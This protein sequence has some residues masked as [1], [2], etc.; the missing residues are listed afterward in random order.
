MR[1]VSPLKR[2]L[3][4]AAPAVLLHAGPVQA[5]LEWQPQA[6]TGPSSR[7][8]FGFAFDSAANVAV[9]LG[10]SSNLTFTAVNR[11]TWTYDGTTWSLV[12]QGGPSARCD[13]A[14]AYDS[15]RQRVVSFGGFNG[16][17][18]GDTWEWDGTSWTNVPISGPDMRAD[19][20]MAF[21]SARGVMV[22]F[23][24]QASNGQIRGDTWEYDGAT[25]TLRATTGPPTRWIQRMAYDSGRGV[26]VMFGGARPGTLLSDTWEWDGTNWTQIMVTGPQGRY[27]HAMA[28]D[29]DRGVVMLFGGQNGLAFGQGVLGDTWEYNGVSWTQIPI[30]GPS[31]RTFVK[32]VY[33][34][35]RQRTVL[36]GGYNGTSTVSDTWEL[37]DKTNTGI[38]DSEDSGE[39]AAVPA[40]RLHLDPNLPNPFRPHTSIRYHLPASGR[41]RLSI[42]DVTGDLVRRLIER[43]EGSGSHVARWDG[44]DE[45][46]AAVASGAYFCRLEAG[47]RTAARRIIL[48]R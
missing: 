23:G 6:V 27:G 40:S 33:D 42:F 26:T 30:T 38:S 9:L 24:G 32:M 5:D 1:S 17:Y 35:N 47:G 25:W 28:Y 48:A 3:L 34:S 10:G 14:M 8:E 46:G 36:F 7:C 13:N 4:G 31:A 20:F 43:E 29:S 21:D 12:N 2:F 11:E 16:A 39:D 22:L 15:I 41:V 37:V 19:S 18:L 45:R 44:R